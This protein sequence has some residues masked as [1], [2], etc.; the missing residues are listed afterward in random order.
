MPGNFLLCFQVKWRDAKFCL[1]TEI[2]VNV[3]LVV[4]KLYVLERSFWGTKI[5][6]EIFQ[7][8]ENLLMR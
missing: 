4:M 6:Q 8:K 7:A 5:R 3:S 1:Y 2:A